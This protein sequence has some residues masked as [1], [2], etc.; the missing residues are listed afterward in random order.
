MI[1]AAVYFFYVQFKSNA[2]ALRAYDFSLN[3]GYLLV[4]FV[5]GSLS[6][7]VGPVVWRMFVNDSLQHKLNFA[8]GYALY[9]VSAMFKYIP[10]KIWTYAA[11]IALMSSKGISKVVLFYI[12]L[13][14]FLCMFFIAGIISLYY[15]LFHI[16]QVGWETAA[17]IF[18]LVILA[19]F[20]F[21]V[22]NNT[23]INYLIRPVNRLLK[24]DIKPIKTRNIILVYTQI[25]YLAACAMLGVALFFLGRGINIELSF[26]HIVAFMATVSLSL[27]LSLLAFFTVG[28]LGV[29]EG[30]MYFMLKQ[31]SNI[32]AALILPVV[33]RLLTFVAELFMLTIAIAIGFRHGY[34]SG[35]G[36]TIN[37]G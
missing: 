13:V 8:E 17:L 36:K 3:A 18:A 4:S 19:D 30:T 23:I 22:W 5:L 7:M 25:F 11:Q 20:S 16:K 24:L 2:D 26:S 35:L 12:N 31:F 32:E 14:S 6:L 1:L 15:Y 28:G 29:R 21:I 10:G 37:G 33:A 34:F 9:C 27:V